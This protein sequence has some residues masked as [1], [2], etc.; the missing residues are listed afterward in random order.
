LTI[1]FVHLLGP[2]LL[3]DSS[4]ITNTPVSA[5]CHLA[6]YVYDRKEDT[7]KNCTRLNKAR[8]AALS[9]AWSYVRA[10]EPTWVM[11]L[12]TTLAWNRPS[13]VNWCSYSG[14]ILMPS[15][16]PNSASCCT[17]LQ[18]IQTSYCTCLGYS[19]LYTLLYTR[20]N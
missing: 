8:L 3:F 1:I 19:C 14:G 9:T 18:R 10:S 11:L 2:P 6:F 4:I 13:F 20:T 7:L 17:L 5:I 16:W 12:K 15:D